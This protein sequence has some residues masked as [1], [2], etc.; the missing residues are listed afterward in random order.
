MITIVT[1][2]DNRTE[3]LNNL[4]HIVKEGKEVIIKN[5]Y[6]QNKYKKVENKFVKIW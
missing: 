1:T 3:V 4:N 6:G 5:N 2:K